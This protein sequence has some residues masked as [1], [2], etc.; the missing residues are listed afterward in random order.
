MRRLSTRSIASVVQ[1]PAGSCINASQGGVGITRLAPIAVPAPGEWQVR[2]WRQDAAGNHEP[3]N[4]SVPVTLRYDPDPPQLGF[5]QSPASD[6]TLVSVQ[7]TDKVSGL[8]SGQIELSRQG[9]AIWQALPTQLH[10]SRLVAR[11]NDAQLPAGTYLLRAT[12]RDLATNQ[13]STDSRL[14]GQP[15]VV[16]LPLRTPTVIRSGVRGTRIVRERVRRDGKR[17][18][19]RRRV[20][21]IEP[22]SK[23]A[24]GREAQIVGRLQTSDGRPLPNAEVQVLSRSTLVP[25]RLEAVIRTDTEG[26]YAY[27]AGPGSTRTFRIAYPGTP[28]TLPATS[29]ATV[30]V[31]A[32]S[33]IRPRPRRLRNGQAVRFTGRLRSLPQPAA[34]KLVELQVTL[35]GRWQT[36]RTTRTSADGSWKVR[37]RFRR[38]CGLTRYRFRAR[39]PGETGYP[40]EAGATKAVRVFVRGPACR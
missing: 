40:F 28:V 16:T 33:S 27:T 32:A 15:M 21:T 35:S 20:E 37:Y 25:E 9:S 12:A 6:P 3:A 39:L 36:F 8:A 14:D 30:R 10:G 1:M 29:E 22:E 31:P 7:V 38:S 4:A 11:I 18:T 34:G 23:V 5:E 13:N 19:V 2:V 26:N 17:R 24:F